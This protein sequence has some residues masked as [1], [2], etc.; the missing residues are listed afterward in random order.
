MNWA[1]IGA[2][3]IILVPVIIF[4]IWVTWIYRDILFEHKKTKKTR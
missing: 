4:T 3:A 2:M 1:L